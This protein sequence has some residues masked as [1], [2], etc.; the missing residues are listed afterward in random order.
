MISS[1]HIKPRSFWMK[2]KGVE[3]RNNSTIL[4]EKSC[5]NK[6][7]PSLLLLFLK[8]SMIPLCTSY[9][10]LIRTNFSSS[11]RPRN[12]EVRV[13]LL[14]E[15]QCVVSPPNQVNKFIQLLCFSS[16]WSNTFPS[17]ITNLHWL[18]LRSKVSILG[19]NF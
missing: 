11:L 3:Y 14:A 18:Q 5:F 17:K 8:V 13:F 12:S 19:L 9:H 2:N 7:M 1:S 10:I 4:C 15:V 6:L 16:M